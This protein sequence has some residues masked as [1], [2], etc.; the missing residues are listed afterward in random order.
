MSASIGAEAFVFRARGA[1]RRRLP[2]PHGV[3][4]GDLLTGAV[5]LLLAIAWITML[6]PANLG[7]S[8]GYV[9]VRGTSMLPT[10]HAGDLVVTERRASYAVGDIVAYRVPEGGP[11]AGLIVIHRIVGGS[12]DE[13]F[14]MQGDNN[15]ALDDWRPKAG[16][17][18]GAPW[19]V[20]PHLGTL[21][22]FFHTPLT[23]ASLGAAIAVALVFDA[24]DATRARKRRAPRRSRPTDGSPA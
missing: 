11:G 22:A 5:L 9:M 24:G 18:V 20:V 2:R 21:L 17:V 6:R 12:A 7:G 3:R 4:A 14:V 10:Y 23:L 1:G 13:G 15:P 19:F 8:A 16:D